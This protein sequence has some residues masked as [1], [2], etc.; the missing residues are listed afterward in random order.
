[1]LKGKSHAALATNRRAWFCCCV[2]FFV[3]GGRGSGLV[4]ILKMVALVWAVDVRAKGIDVL[5]P[6]YHYQ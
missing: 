2:F 6:F 1:M 4:L 3:L 5:S